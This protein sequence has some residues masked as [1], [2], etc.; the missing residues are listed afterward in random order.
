MLVKTNWDNIMNKLY[1]FS[2]GFGL[3]NISPFCLKM[4]MALTYLTIDFELIELN[5][6]RKA[7][8]AKLPYMELN[9]ET[10]SDS[11]IMFEQLNAITDGKLYN[12][13]TAEQKAIGTAFSRLAEDHLYWLLVASRWLEDDWFPHVDAAFFAPM[14]IPLRW[15]IPSIARKQVRKTLQL[16]GLGAHSR[17]EMKAFARR[18][19]QAISDAIGSKPFLLGNEISAFDFT[20]GSML[21]GILDNKPDTWLSPIAREIDHLV[22][23]T[24]RV[25][26][27]I[28]VYG[29]ID[30]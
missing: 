9:G 19:L 10:L 21:S 4:E 30:P 13:L 25:Q 18:D 3:R 5:D 2:P 7:P 29:R 24:E 27:T 1:I 15:I 26:Q 8:K 17:E 16:H 23:Y 28:G 14:P 6:P 22:D 12:G 11:E 20:V